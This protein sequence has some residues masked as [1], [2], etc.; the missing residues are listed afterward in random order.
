MNIVARTT[1]KALR[2]HGVPELPV[3]EQALAAAC[4]ASP[5]PFGRKQYGEIYRVSA[6]DPDWV[7]LSL[8]TAAQS[9]GEGS[10][11]LWDMASS[12]PDPEIARQMQQHAIDESRHSRGYVTM[13]GLI[14]P[15]VGDAEL[16][17]R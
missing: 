7:A 14:F 3:Y 9:E 10:R 12:T 11:H 1:T 6:K 16:R 2:A 15:K 17:K 13:L 4:N 8:I 5:P